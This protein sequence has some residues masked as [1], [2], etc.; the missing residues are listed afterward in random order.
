MTI[1]DFLLLALATWRLSWMLAYETGPGAVF[2]RLRFM[3]GA[4]PPVCQQQITTGDITN[5]FCCIMCLSVW[6]ALL[7]VVAHVYA[8]P[9]VWVFALSGAAVLIQKAVKL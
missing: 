9:V 1:V 6:V 4:S 3:L 5:V 7:M 2:E 8:A